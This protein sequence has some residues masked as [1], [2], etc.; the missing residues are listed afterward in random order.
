DPAYPSERIAYM[1]DNSQLPVLLTQQKLVASLPEH[2]VRVVC[3]DSDWEEISTESNL[4]PITSLTPENLVYVIY[5][6]GSTGK[7]KGVLIPHSGL[8]NLVFWH[9]HAFEVTLSDRAT[10][11]AGTAF[12]ASVWEM[13][14]YL[15]SGA[16]IYLVKPEILLS[17]EELRDW[18]LTQ[19]ITITFVPTPIAEKLLS[20]HWPCDGALRITY[21]SLI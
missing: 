10:Q 20:L 6:S 8:L 16:S 18:L 14:P 15:A 13:W 7:P 2:Q 21:G 11:L 3:L 19:E 4:S 1:L 9:Q 5:T 17:P 12:D